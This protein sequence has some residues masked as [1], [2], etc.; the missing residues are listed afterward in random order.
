[1]SGQDWG[2][3]P[4]DRTFHDRS[5][6]DC[7]VAS[8]N[9]FLL[10]KSSQFARKDLARTYVLVEGSKAR[11]LGYY[12]L[13]SHTVVYDALPEDEKRGLPSIDLPVVLIGRLAVDQSMQGQG[14]GEFLLIDALRR[15]EYLASKIEI[16]AVE[17]DAIDDNARR[18]YLRY[19]FVSLLDDPRHLFLPLRV[20]RKL[21]LPPL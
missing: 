10:R 15:V 12:A 20:I 9:D 1:M 7:G 17:V 14:M 11:V 3:Q 4:L 6:F 16:Q 13:S 19:G 18:F 8:H 2:I 21:K 5:Q